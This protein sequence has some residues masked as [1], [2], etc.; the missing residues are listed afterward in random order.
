MLPFQ[1]FFFNILSPSSPIMGHNWKYDLVRSRFILEKVTKIAECA[2]NTHLQIPPWQQWKFLSTV[3]STVEIFQHHHVVK[4]KIFENHHD[5][6]KKTI[7]WLLSLTT[8]SMRGIEIQ[9]ALQ[10]KSVF[11]KLFWNGWSNLNDSFGRPPWK[12]DA[13]E[14]LKKSAI[15]H[16]C[17][18]GPVALQ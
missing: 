16:I 9:K 6:R 3:K 15:H 8:A 13:D 10:W 14:M 18:H 17:A 5:N 1:L 2:K 11:I 12:L 4:V 7:I